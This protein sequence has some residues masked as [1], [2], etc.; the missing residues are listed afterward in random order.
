MV[1]NRI[2][3]TMSA[4][5]WSIASAKAELSH[6]VRRAQREPQILENR[7][8]PIAV[9]IAMDDYRKF[10]ERQRR[11][12]NWQEFLRLGAE[13]RARGGYELEIPPRTSRPDPFRGRGRRA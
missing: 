6:V 2:V 1:T 9:V 10:S 8:E 11:E 5:R 4:N 7:G 12:A 3:M 13:L